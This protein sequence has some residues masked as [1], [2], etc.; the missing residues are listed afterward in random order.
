[1]GS[2]MKSHVGRRRIFTDPNTGQKIPV[3][4]VKDEIR[5]PEELEGGWGK[6]RFATWL[7]EELDDEGYF[8][9][10]FPYWRN[11]KFAGQYSLRA[12]PCV[13]RFLFEEMSKRGWLEK[14]GWSDSENRKGGKT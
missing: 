1:M 2:E 5:Y 4:V 14:K 3:S 7:E 12:E 10:S 9:I 8:T 6:Y 13:V 11:G